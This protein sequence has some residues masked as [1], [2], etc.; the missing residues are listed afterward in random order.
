MSRLYA[1]PSESELV[2]YDIDEGEIVEVPTL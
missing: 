1:P 2:D